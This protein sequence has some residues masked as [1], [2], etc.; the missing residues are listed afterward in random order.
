MSIEVLPATSKRFDDVAVTVGPTKPTSSV[1]WR[2]RHRLA[3]AA[4]RSCLS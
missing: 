3:D 4:P 1:C 2:L